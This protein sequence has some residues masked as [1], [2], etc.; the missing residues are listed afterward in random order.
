MSANKSAAK[1]SADMKER[2]QDPAYRAAITASMK[3]KPKPPHHVEMARAA[4]R[5]T[6]A[7]RAVL[8]AGLPLLKVNVDRAV[9]MLAAL[10]PG[11]SKVK[12]IVRILTQE[13]KQ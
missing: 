1:L 11:K 12:R 2:W 8:Q 7:R 13:A 9:A 4:A 10:S 6:F 3:G 5:R